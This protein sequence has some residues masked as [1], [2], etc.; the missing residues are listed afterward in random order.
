MKKWILAAALAAAGLAGGRALAQPPITLPPG[1]TPPGSAPGVLPLPTPDAGSVNVPP[2]APGVGLPT[3][4]PPGAPGGSAFPGPTMGG[5]GGPAGP[6]GPGGYGPQGMYGGPGAYNTT[7]APGPLGYHMPGTGQY[8]S[9][10]FFGGPILSSSQNLTR[11]PTLPVYMA[12]PWYLYWPYD[13]H[14]QTI[15]PMAHGLYYPPPGN[16]SNAFMPTRYPGYMPNNPNP[17]FPMG[18]M[19]Q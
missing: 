10:R 17:Q 5:M 4:L 11:M 3:P 16:T 1:A 13:G 18:S 15:A 6:A 14:F 19:R 7:G 2:A 9:R 12:A 8:W